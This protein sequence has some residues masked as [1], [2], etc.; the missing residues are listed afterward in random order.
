MSKLREQLKKIQLNLKKP[1]KLGTIERGD[2]WG[3][4]HS[5]VTSPHQFDPRHWLDIKFVDKD[6]LPEGAIDAGGPTLDLLQHLMTT[7]QESNL[8]KGPPGEKYPSID[9]RGMCQCQ[10]KIKC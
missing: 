9:I 5:W 2:E 1:S 8:F 6:G 4:F 7:I 3:C 10:F